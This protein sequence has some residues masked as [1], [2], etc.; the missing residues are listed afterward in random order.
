MEDI[1][2]MAST[3]LPVIGAF[4][5]SLIGKERQRRSLFLTHQCNHPP[6]P[7]GAH[8]SVKLYLLHEI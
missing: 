6:R 7:E 1:N 4:S 2:I 3:L 5:A 8:L